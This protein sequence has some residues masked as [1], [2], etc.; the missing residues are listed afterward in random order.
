MQSLDD[1]Y[2]MLDVFTS[3]GATH[4]DVTFLDI[5]GGKRG[6]RSAPDRPSGAPFAAE[7]PARFVRTAE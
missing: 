5:D 6:F 1:A 7:A 4:F 3:V 2:R